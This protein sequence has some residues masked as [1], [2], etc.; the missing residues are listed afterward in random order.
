MENNSKI[1]IDKLSDIL[2]VSESIIKRDIDKLKKAGTIY[3]KGS[4]IDENW[5]VKKDESE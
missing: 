4:L 2:K 1:T 3:R 5:I